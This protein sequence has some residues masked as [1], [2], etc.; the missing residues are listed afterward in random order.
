M[1]TLHRAEHFKY[2]SPLSLLHSLLECIN[3]ILH[4]YMAAS[5]SN[6]VQVLVKLYRQTI[7]VLAQLPDEAAYKQSTLA[8]TQSRLA[9]AETVCY[10]SCSYLVFHSSHCVAMQAKTADDIEK[11][12]GQ[13]QVEEVI[14]QVRTWL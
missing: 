8:L 9:V 12:L 6:T 11:A 5:R 3:F 7:G 2:G 13:G 1:L 14:A 10:S 4:Q